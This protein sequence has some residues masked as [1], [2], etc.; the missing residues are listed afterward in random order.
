MTTTATPAILVHHHVPFTTGYIRILTQSDPHAPNG[1][2]H[3]G[4][5]CAE[6]TGW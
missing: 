6:K 4:P 1:V 3:I 5:I 2:S